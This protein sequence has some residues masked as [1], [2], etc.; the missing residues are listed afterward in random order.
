MDVDHNTIFPRTKVGRDHQ[1]RDMFRHGKVIDRKMDEK[2]GPLLR[3]QFL[4]KQGLIS[5][6]LP[7]KK[8]GS[9]KTLHSYVNKIGDDVSVCML[10]NGVENGFVDGSFFNEGNPPPAGV[11]IDTRHFLTEDGTIIEYR[12][13]DSTFNLDA[14]AAGA[15]ARTGSGG[16]VIVKAG[17]VQITAG[18]IEVVATEMITLTAPIISLNGLMQFNGDIVHVGN[19]NTSGVHTDSNGIHMGAERKDE[20]EELKRRV[21]VLE[22]EVSNLKS[23]LR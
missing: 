15:G 12:E 9:R 2:R 8:F 7:V 14:S 22:N 4:D 5:A 13:I 11:D 3:V 10:P 21:V 20:I 18:T 19:M 16:T 23:R 17:L 6:W 1:M